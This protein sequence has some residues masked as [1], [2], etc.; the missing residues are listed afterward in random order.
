MPRPALLHASSHHPFL[1]HLQLSKLRLSHDHLFSA[2][3]A[4]REW[5]IR[6]QDSKSTCKHGGSCRRPDSCTLGLSQVQLPC[7]TG[8]LLPIWSLLSDAI[9]QTW[10]NS[11]TVDKYRQSALNAGREGKNPPKAPLRVVHLVT[12][13]SPVLGL[14]LPHGAR[15]L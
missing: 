6:L 1:P 5:N 11:A 15:R 7:L 13:G 4:K 3:S 9:A 2:S 8:T 14:A 10:A 12:D